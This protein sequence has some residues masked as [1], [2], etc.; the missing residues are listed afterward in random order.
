MRF[1]LALAVCYVHIGSLNSSS[2]AD[3]GD[4]STDRIPQESHS[5][6]ASR[7]WCV[8]TPLFF[9]FGRFFISNGTGSEI[10]SAK[11]FRRFY[12]LRILAMHPMY[13]LSLLAFTLNFVVQCHSSN[14][15]KSFDRDRAPLKG[16]YFVCQ[17]TSRS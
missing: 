11:D 9:L 13:L 12:A 16:E 10:K 8:H 7:G 4:T 1:I 6:T 3:T 14:Y 17:A 2:W 15:I 5:W